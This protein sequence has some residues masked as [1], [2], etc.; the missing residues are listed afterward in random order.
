MVRAVGIFFWRVT[1]ETGAGAIS[2][3]H[4]GVFLKPN[5]VGIIRRNEG[6]VAAIACA[7]VV[8]RQDGVRVTP[9]VRFD[10]SICK[11]EHA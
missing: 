2:L 3:P 6:E 7:A 1:R 11:R 5:Q 10:V 4:R 9:A 8:R